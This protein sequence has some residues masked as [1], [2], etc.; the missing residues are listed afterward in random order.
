[1]TTPPDSRRVVDMLL[2]HV[3]FM[4]QRLTSTELDIGIHLR[5]NA[6]LYE[7]L[8]CLIRSRIEGRATVPEPN[9][10]LKCKS[11]LARDRELGWLLSTLERVYASPAI[12]PVDASGE[13]P[14]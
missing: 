11:M 1:M 5:G 6:P 10:P 4:R 8:T 7:A 12:N 3:P 13:P 2:D 14:A 9:D